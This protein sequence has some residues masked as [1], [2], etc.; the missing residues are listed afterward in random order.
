MIGI[1]NVQIATQI[2]NFTNLK[3]GACPHKMSF[4]HIGSKLAV[5]ESQLVICIEL[6]MREEATTAIQNE[7][8]LKEAYDTAR[9]RLGQIMKDISKKEAA[10]ILQKYY[11]P[12]KY[13]EY[14]SLD[15]CMARLSLSAYSTTTTWVLLDSARNAY[16]IVANDEKTFCALFVA[17]TGNFHTWVN[18]ESVLEMAKSFLE[19]EFKVEGS[20]KAIVVPAA[21][22]AASSARSAL[23]AAEVVVVKI[24]PAETPARSAGVSAPVDLLQAKESE[25][26]SLREGVL[27]APHPT[28][29]AEGAETSALCAEVSAATTVPIPKKKIIRKRAPK[30]SE[31]SEA[32]KKSKPE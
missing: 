3:K 13:H 27:A 12:L 14:V 20:V 26:P 16:C 29:Q 10:Y 5:P 30:S 8:L 6:G 28:S 2:K 11:E 21:A 17:K 9:N 23:E 22:A 15:A 19:Q 24:E 32:T 4:V 25:T 18:G 1:V 7:P 31:D